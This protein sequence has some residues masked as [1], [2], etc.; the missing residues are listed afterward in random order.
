[1]ARTRKPGH[2]DGP[3]E[4]GRDAVQAVVEALRNA[5]PQI[6]LDPSGTAGHPGDPA[7]VRGVIEALRDA[8][9]RLLDALKSDD[10][11]VRM[12][13]V[14]AFGRIGDATAATPTEGDL[15]GTESRKTLKRGRKYTMMSP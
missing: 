6:S 3:V 14:E 8:F 13:A 5:G 15:V 11:Q 2:S 10:A 1:M 4:A 9:P 12:E 7:A